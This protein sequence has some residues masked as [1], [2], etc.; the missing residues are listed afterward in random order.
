MV[1]VANTTACFGVVN[2]RGHIEKPAGRRLMRPRVAP[3]PVLAWLLVL[4]LPTLGTAHG[5]NTDAN[6]CHTNKKTGDYHCHGARTSAPLPAPQTPALAPTPSPSAGNAAPLPLTPSVGPE[7]GPDGRFQRSTA[8]TNAFQRAHPCPSTGKT[9]GA[10]PG[11]VIDHI[12][13]LKRGGPDAPSNMQWQTVEEA[14][15][16]DKLE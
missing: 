4:A 11:Y 7:R 3:G 16:K 5:G 15:A 14:K 1:G 10:C 12:M 8:A 6:G 2:V 9:S 13:P